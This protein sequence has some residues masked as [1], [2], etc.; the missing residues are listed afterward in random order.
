MTVLVVGTSIVTAQGEELGIL[1]HGAT[2]DVLV[3]VTLVVGGCQLQGLVL[4]ASC[5]C[6][7]GEP[8]LVKDFL[9]RLCGQCVAVHLLHREQVR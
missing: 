7:L 6:G 5:I 2:N 3:A 9:S 4:L 1:V 8:L